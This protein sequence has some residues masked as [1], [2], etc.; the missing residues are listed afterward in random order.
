V[1]G[2]L[3]RVDAVGFAGLQRVLKKETTVH[4]PTKS[5]ENIV[6]LPMDQETMTVIKNRTAA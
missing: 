3:A 6:R 5:G 2:S 1:T 4:K